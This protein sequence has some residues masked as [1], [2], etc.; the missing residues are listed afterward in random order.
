MKYEIYQLNMNIESVKN[1][2]KLFERWDWLNKY[3]GGFNFN[4]YK[5]V[6]EGDIDTDVVPGPQSHTD[7][8]EHLFN[9]FNMFHPADFHGHSLSVSDVV[10]L[11]GIVY[12]C[13]S[14]GWKE[15]F[16]LEEISRF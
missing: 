4:E 7:I 11:E 16:N 14:F 12:Y 10:V 5:K 9:T 3:D 8:L 2:H 15:V 6:Y 13:D 1:S